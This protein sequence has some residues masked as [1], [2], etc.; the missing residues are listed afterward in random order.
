MFEYLACESLGTH[1][2]VIKIFYKTTDPFDH[3]KNA[4]AK[5]VL[6]PCIALNN[7]TCHDT[8]SKNWLHVDEHGTYKVCDNRIL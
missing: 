3:N 7:V 8:I 2:F 5:W 1:W 6:S 4:L